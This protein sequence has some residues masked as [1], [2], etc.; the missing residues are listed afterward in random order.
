MPDYSQLTQGFRRELENHSDA[1]IRELAADPRAVRAAELAAAKS[2]APIRSVGWFVA[3][4]R[5]FAESPAEI[6]ALIRGSEA[7]RGGAAGPQLP[8]PIVVGSLSDSGRWE[9]PIELVHSVD[10]DA[11]NWLRSRDDWQQCDL[12]AAGIAELERRGRNEHGT[13]VL[14]RW[15]RIVRLGPDRERTEWP[16]DLEPVQRC[17]DLDTDLEAVWQYCETVRWNS[18]LVVDLAECI[19]RAIRAAW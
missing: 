17:G 7:D 9:S 1:R 6:D 12:I 11:A 15:K 4:F 8:P 10:P 16:V 14:D 13:G 5:G 3:V 19:Q 18:V 2:R